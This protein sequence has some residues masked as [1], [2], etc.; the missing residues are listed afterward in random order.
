M[1]EQTEKASEAALSVS[2]LEEINEG[3]EARKRRESVPEEFWIV[4]RDSR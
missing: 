4:I 2:M 3:K 1:A